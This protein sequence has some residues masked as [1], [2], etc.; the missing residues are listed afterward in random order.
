MSGGD[1]PPLPE[2]P[3]VS[4]SADRGGIWRSLLELD[5]LHDEEMAA[6]KLKE[7]EAKKL[8]SSSGAN[9]RGRTGKAERKSI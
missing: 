7:T 9:G 1:F 5:L 8:F 4:C 6:K 3:I 2:K